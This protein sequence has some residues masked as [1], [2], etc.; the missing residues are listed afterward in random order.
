M[1]SRKKADC[2]LD[3]I[4]N[5]YLLSYVFHYLD[6]KTFFRV[7]FGSKKLCQRFNLKRMYQ[8][9]NHDLASLEFDLFSNDWFL[10]NRIIDETIYCFDL[11]PELIKIIKKNTH[12]KYII[13]ITHFIIQY[14]K[15]DKSIKNYVLQID[16]KNGEINDFD[17]IKNNLKEYLNK[18]NEL[19][20][21]SIDLLSKYSNHLLNLKQIDCQFIQNIDISLEYFNKKLIYIDNFDCNEFLD[22]TNFKNLRRLKLIGKNNTIMNQMV[23]LSIEQLN[24]LEFLSLESVYIIVI[25][26]K[27]IPIFQNLKNLVLIDNEK[28]FFYHIYLDLNNCNLSC[29]S[30]YKN[31][32]FVLNYNT[33]EKW[34]ISSQPIKYSFEQLESFEYYNNDERKIKYKLNFL[35]YN[36]D[37]NIFKRKTKFKFIIYSCNH[38]LK[39]FLLEF[40]ERNK[41]FYFNFIFD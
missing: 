4:N 12:I 27:D 37:K 36:F 22:L 26:S 19:H 6:K 23:R 21:N 20:I 38:K 34:I 2:L 33:N 9:Y 10:N 29:I 39:K 7:T 8:R 11:I 24:K 32:L 3:K 40:K 18:I 17:I 16:F 5:K 41:S 14:I 28:I 13:P 25:D 1:S 35:Q 15:N 30:R 31:Q